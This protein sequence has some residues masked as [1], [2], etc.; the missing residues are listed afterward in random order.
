[1]KNTWTNWL[2]RDGKWQSV[3]I[4]EA[5]V[6]SSYAKRFA[7]AGITTLGQ[8]QDAPD[9][10]LLAKPGIGLKSLGLLREQIK[11]CQRVT[12]RRERDRVAQAV[13]AM[14]DAEFLA[15]TRKPPTNTR[16]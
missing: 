10:L 1:M 14:S 12:K 11:M 4:A 7:H 5:P 15:F 16:H 6:V 3:L 13:A 8:A 9:E 2:V